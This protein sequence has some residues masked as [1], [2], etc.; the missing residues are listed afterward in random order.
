MIKSFYCAIFTGIVLLLF[1]FN[2]FSQSIVTS[3]EFALASP[4]NEPDDR[5]DVVRISDNEF[6]T[7]AKAKGGQ[8]GKSNFLLQKFD[9]DL[10]NSWTSPLIAESYEDYKELYYNGKEVVLLSVH[11]LIAEKKTKLMAYGFD[12]NNGK[13]IWNKELESYSVGDWET[14]LHKGRVKESFV[15]LVCEHVNQDYVTPFE[16]KHNIVFSPDQSKF[17]SYVYNYGESNLTASIGVYDTQCNSL[18]KG[19]VSIDNNYTNFGIYINNKG[20]VFILNANNFGAVNFIQFDLDTKDFFILQLPNSNYMKDDFHVQFLNDNEVYVANTEVKDGKIYGVMYSKFNFQTEQVDMSKF[21]ELDASFKSK[22]NTERKNNKQMKGEDDW[23]DYD[24]THFY[25]DKS[26]EAFI[27]LEKR[28]LHA[29][30][31]PHIGRESFDKTHK[32]EFTGHVQAETILMFAFDPNGETK[33]KNYILKNQ[34]YPAS[35]GLNSISFIMNRDY[36]SEIRLLYASS[37]SFDGSLHNLNYVS[38]NAG[39]GT[40]KIKSLPN[41]EKLTLVRDY[42][43]FTADNSFILVGKKGMVGKSSMIIKYKF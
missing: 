14:H 9:Q 34:V 39:D 28:D 17:V 36:A 37:E 26:E 40:Y 27:V 43:F 4:F 22:V 7:L 38:V 31:Y 3:K 2:L 42:S 10:N 13:Q 24:I 11:H 30:G 5:S 18:K 6:I 19:K 25:I 12:I 41:D 8:S 33:W 1:S 15:D 16:Y 32:V 23:M 35:D 21:Q 20:Q 29:D